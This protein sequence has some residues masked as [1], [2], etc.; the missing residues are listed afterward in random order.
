MSNHFKITIK[1]GR[2]YSKIYVNLMKNFLLVVR[3]T[4]WM[5]TDQQRLVFNSVFLCI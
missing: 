5:K 4:K 3:P 2:I 1:C